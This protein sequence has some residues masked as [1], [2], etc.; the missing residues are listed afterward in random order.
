M[1][2]SFERPSADMVARDDHVA[3][4]DIGSNSMRLVVYDGPTRSPVPLYNEKIMC[5]L[6]RTVEKTGRLNPEG[7]EL[8]LDN[9]VRFRWLLEGMRVVRVDAVA[10]A[11]V[12]DAADGDAFVQTVTERTGFEVRTVT[13]QEEAR[14][15]ALGVL[16]GTPGADGLM[17]DLGGGSLELVGLENGVIGSRQVTLPIGPLRLTASSGGR[18]DKAV[19][20]IEKHLEE[21]DWIRACKGRDFHPVGG[22]W[23]T[24]AKLHMEQ[25]GHP[26][27]IIHHYTVEGPALRD[28]LGVLARQSRSSIE[29]MS[30]VSKRRVDTMP[31]AALVM[32]RLLRTV[33]PARVV[34][35]AHGL[36]EGLLFDLLDED[37]RR[38]DPLIAACTRIARRLGR[39]GIGDALAGWTAPLF[40]G[41]DEV[42]ARLRHAACLLSDVGWSEHPDYRA[43]HAFLRVLRMPFAGI[44]HAERA[45]LALACHVRYA[46]RPDGSATRRMLALAGEGGVA[47]ANILGLAL[48]L[49]HTL[50]GGVTALVQ[51]TSL[52]LEE[53]ELLLVLPDDDRVVPGDAVQRRLDALARTV[54]RRGR[55]VSTHP[56]GA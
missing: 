24:L 20:T 42:A 55:I 16:S 56:A 23:R 50:T 10:T 32:E 40:P 4:I 15:S 26:L 29:R 7:V 6:G 53:G 33:E 18:P 14:L 13:G 47:K 12:R 37:E 5:G 8:A 41:E 22:S 35:S 48:R 31:Y 21:Q 39:F 43:E 25:V 9:L 3:V 17:G 54:N 45:W 11:A 38:K 30:G 1:P 44:D 51:R 36:R 52:R 28:F 49:A 27:H 19:P 34:F 2:I 46:G